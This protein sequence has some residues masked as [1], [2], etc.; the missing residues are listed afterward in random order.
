MMWC[1]AASVTASRYSRRCTAHYHLCTSCIQVIDGFSTKRLHDPPD[2]GKLH[3]E[4]N[5]SEMWQERVWQAILD[6]KA[7]ADLIQPG[8]RVGGRWC[9]Y[10]VL[11][12]GGFWVPCAPPLGSCATAHPMT[13]L[14]LIVMISRS[15]CMIINVQPQPRP[16]LPC[17]I[18]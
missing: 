4:D 18:D 15:R 3:A 8:A 11:N 6:P 7:P 5:K 1:T 12:I 2:T 16:S 17:L 14:T 13:L 10:I 9:A